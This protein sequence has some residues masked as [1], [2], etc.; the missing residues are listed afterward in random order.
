VKRRVSGPPK[1]VERPRR[2]VVSIAWTS[3]ARKPRGYSA[4][5]VRRAVAA[6]L[7]V[8]AGDWPQRE[9]SIVFVDDA[10]LAQ[11]HADWL[12][13]PT[14]TDVI[15]FDLR[16]DPSGPAGELYVSV[17]RALAVAAR[18]QAS[19]LRELLLYVVHGV[20]HLCG[21]DDHEAADRRRMRAAER[22]AFARLERERGAR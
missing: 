19:P 4:A 10:D 17:E 9:L 8:G 3:S 18:R 20:L 14:L 6:A 16:D 11:M 13:D 7:E 15:T 5:A 1:R 22:R 2:A 21:F 12:N